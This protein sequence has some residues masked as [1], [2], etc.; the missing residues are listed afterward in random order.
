[1]NGKCLNPPHL[2]SEIPIRTPRYT[3]RHA[4][5]VTETHLHGIQRWSLRL[6]RDR[7]VQ[8][9]TSGPHIPEG[10]SNEISLPRVVV[11]YRSERGVRVGLRFSAAEPRAN[12][13]R[14]GDRR[15][16]QRADRAGE[17]RFGHMTK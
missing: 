17:P 8:A 4:G 13:A 12:R 3:I 6:I 2:L 15:R 7:T 16:I 10:A 11:Q 9:N 14:I 1:M 5:R